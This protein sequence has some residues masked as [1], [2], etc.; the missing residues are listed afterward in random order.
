MRIL[1]AGLALLALLVAGA[2]AAR[3]AQAPTFHGK[4]DKI[5]RRHCDECHRAGDI[6]PSALDDPA[7]AR[8]R[9]GAIVEEIETGRMPPWRPTR[10]VGKFVNERGV[11]PSELATLRRWRDAGAPEGAAPAKTRPV[12]ST[13]GWLLG[14]P[15]A[16][17]DYGEP[18]TVPAFSHDVYRCFP[19]K[20]PFG[21]AV[22]LSGIDVRPGDRRVLHHVV[23]YVEGAD[24]AQALDDAEPGPGYECFGGSGTS[25]PSVL[26]GWAP[27]N[28]AR[29]FP[30][31]TAMV[32]GAEDTVVVQCHYHAKDVDVV[33]HTTVGL[34]LSSEPDPQAMFLLPVLDDTFTIPAGASAHLVEALLDPSE[35]SGGL[36]QVSG[37]V[38]AVLPHMHLLGRRIDVDLLLPD[39][40]EQRLVEILDWDFDWQDTYWLTRP[41]PVPAGTKF[42]VR[43]VY[44]NSDANPENPNVPPKDVSY[45]E[46]TTDEMCLA[47]LAVTLG[48][49][50]ADRP[51]AVRK[52]AV[53]AKGRLVVS[54]K[55]LGKGGR[56]E[57]DGHP[58]PDSSAAGSNRL[59]SAS[60]WSALAPATGPTEVRVRR[61]DGRLS[62]PVSLVR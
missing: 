57:I 46:R 15:D 59:V 2:S 50:K 24:A 23:M 21:R 37:R 38:H 29:Y 10:G 51:P 11:S 61:T 44:D 55:N 52:A 9:A 4:V 18:F 25:S 17:L 39:G 40:T 41:A 33:D 6:G 3:V 1:A 35:L 56:I 28:R 16:V 62:P 30:R 42:R 45:G 13:D 53:D 32:L 19:I 34:Y 7:V 5:L 31:G 14:P 36:L 54:A 8:L 12:V 43:A 20:N 26:G 58:V 22:W 48:S 49:A 27:G 47:F 60:D